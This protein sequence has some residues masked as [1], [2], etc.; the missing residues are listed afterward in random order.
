MR[1][2]K[3][4]V[5]E[6]LF[7]EN[8]DP[9]RQ[10]LR[11]SV[12]SL[13]QVSRAIRACNE[14]YG[15]SLSDRNPA[16]FLKDLLRGRNTSR[17]WPESVAALGYTAVQRTGSGDAFEFILYGAGQTAPFAD[18]F[19]IMSDAPRCAIQSLSMPLAMKTLGRTDE[20]WLIQTALNLR[21]VETHFAVASPVEMLEI[22]HLQ[23][24]IKL[25]KTEIDALFLGRV[26][27]A[28]AEFPVIVTCEAKHY[29]DPFI[30]QQ[31]VNQ[32]QA[33][34]GATEVALVIPLGL[35]AVRG[36][37]FFVSEFAQVSREEADSLADLERVAC[38][39][40]ELRPS[41][42]GI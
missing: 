18:R 37:G 14:K 23:M 13:E 9:E 10:R 11:K 32:V 21:V 29:S 7:F 19:P 30:P 20:S 40:Y 39:L 4:R 25:R 26:R 22:I 2:A 27:T 1:S 33:A 28:S 12:M 41:V 34:F 3:T 16:N 5:V 35:K 6:H 38:G 15:T 36:V 17:N 31:I 8:W 24:S 42:K